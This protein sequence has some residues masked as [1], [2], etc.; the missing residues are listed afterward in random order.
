[1]EPMFTVDL[2]DFYRSV[3]RMYGRT[4]TADTGETI[5][6]YCNKDA[7]MVYVD[8][9]ARLIWSSEARGEAAFQC[10]ACKRFVVGGRRYL[11]L[12][13]PHDIDPRMQAWSLHEQSTHE[14]IAKVLVGNVEYWHPIEP[15]GK[16]YEFDL[17]EIAD[18]AEEAHR[19]YSIGAHRAAILL[20]RA[21][22]EATAKKHGITKGQLFQKIEAMGAQGVI[23]PQTVEA[24]HGVRDIGND[25]AHGDFATA[26]VSKEDASDVLILMDVVLNDAFAGDSALRK[27]ASRR[28]AREEN[29]PE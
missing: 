12:M 19:C 13:T 21:V 14:E 7:H 24:A 16:T 29:P 9:S 15:V 5:C 26:D 3:E 6:P 22:I 4:M 28:E 10:N 2:A 17:G 27:L 8:G 25:M 23:R 20:A 1:M 18:P 11:G